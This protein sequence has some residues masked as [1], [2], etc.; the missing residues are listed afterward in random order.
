MFGL[1]MV[2]LALLSTRYFSLSPPPTTTTTHPTI[3]TW[4]YQSF[5]E[6]QMI[7]WVEMG[8]NMVF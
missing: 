4:E 8:N 3:A 6:V 2:V 5:V 7:Y 1:R